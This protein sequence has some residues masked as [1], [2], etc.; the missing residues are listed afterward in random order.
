MEY[1]K[2][3]TREIDANVRELIDVFRF[4]L[5]YKILFR[6]SGIEFAGLREYIPE[7]DDASKIDWK[8][9]L[10]T[11]KLHV[12]QYEEE[13]ELN[14]YIL[15]DVSSSMLFGTYEKLKSE[16]ATVM[17]GTIAYAAIESN[18]N[19]GFGMFSDDI[20]ISLTPTGD[21]SQYYHILTLMVDPRCYGGECNLD[22]ALSHVVNSID[23][24]TILF[25]VSDFI[26][27]GEGWEDAIKMVSGKLDK[28]I[29]IMIRDP[30]DTFLPEG[31]GNIKFAD[32]FSDKILMVNVDKIRKKY[33]NETKKQ[34]EK[35]EREFINSNAGF[36]KI[37]TNEPF[38]KPFVEYLQLY[39]LNY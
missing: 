17:V 16:Y 25:I 4:I 14:V 22:K 6:G 18:D 28:V 29:G 15:L 1:I 11:K 13:R 3:L 21:L 31:V 5:R 2:E 19:V 30:R 37:Y 32:P 26:G 23:E 38:V 7:H 9:S 34:E 20:K 36:V 33:E 12:K 39:A 8:A 24:R 35:I 10:R 27:I